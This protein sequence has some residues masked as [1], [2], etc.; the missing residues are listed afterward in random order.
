MIELVRYFAIVP[1]PGGRGSYQPVD[2]GGDTSLISGLER[3][4]N[5]ENLCCVTASGGGVGHDQADLLG[6]VDDEHG[7]DGEGNSLAVDVGQV[8]LV[9][10]LV[11][12]GDFAVGIGDDREFELSRGDFVDVLD[13]LLVGIKRVGT[14]ETAALANA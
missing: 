10:H 4:D 1:G 14:L 6:G 8:L 3:V 13:P 5:P 9:N 7:A 12:E 11:E 2:R